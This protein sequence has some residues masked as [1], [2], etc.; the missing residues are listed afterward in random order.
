VETKSKHITMNRYARRKNWEWIKKDNIG[1]EMTKRL[2]DTND[3]NNKD[4]R[5]QLNKNGH[6]T[7]RSEKDEKE[8]R[9]REKQYELNNSTN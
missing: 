1:G 7:P 9:R 6:R 2:V 8:N 5:R 3:V 4:M